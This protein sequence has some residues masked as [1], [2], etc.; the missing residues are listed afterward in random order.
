MAFSVSEKKNECLHVGLVYP[1]T[2][3][4]FI[5]PIQ[6]GGSESARADGILTDVFFQICNF[7]VFI[8]KNLL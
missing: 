2:K 1:K 6:R 7:C 8:N 3:L 4:E 5:Y